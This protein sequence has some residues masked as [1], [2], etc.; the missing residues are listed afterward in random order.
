MTINVNTFGFTSL[1]LIKVEVGFSLL[2]KHG[3][4]KIL[5]DALN[6]YNLKNIFYLI[7][8]DLYVPKRIRTCFFYTY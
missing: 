5:E 2:K 6:V 1:S 7:L 4:S 3:S 8:Y